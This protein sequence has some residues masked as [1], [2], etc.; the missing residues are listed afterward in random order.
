MAWV[1][2]LGESPDM[3]QARGM[4]PIAFDQGAKPRL[5]GSLGSVLAIFGRSQSHKDQ[6]IAS[7]RNSAC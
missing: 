3:A 6:W 5:L 2:R 4:R 1:G 7:P